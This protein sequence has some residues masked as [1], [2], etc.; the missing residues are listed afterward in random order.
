MSFSVSLNTRKGSRIEWAGDNLNTLFAQRKNLLNPSFLRMLFDIV[1]FNNAGKKIANN[2]EAHKANNSTQFESVE[3]FLKRKNFSDVF[4]D[5]YLLPM[6]G[7]IWSCSPKDMMQFPI[8]TLM[9]FCNNHGLL[10]IIDRPQW[11]TVKLSLIHISEPTR[12]Y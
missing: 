4:R 3:E 11:M 8:Q 7:S 6:I 5:W 10:N 1:K 12:P 2:I 9:Q